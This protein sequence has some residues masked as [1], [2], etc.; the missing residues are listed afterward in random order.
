MD[1]GSAWVHLSTYL[2]R[3]YLGKYPGRLQNGYS[4][5]DCVTF[6][7]RYLV[8]TW[9]VGASRH[10]A[11]LYAVK[12]VFGTMV[13]CAALVAENLGREQSRG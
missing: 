2:G 3:Q 9:V 1:I 8:N 11:V 6:G 10:L 4:I 5:H 13:L 7:S 12:L